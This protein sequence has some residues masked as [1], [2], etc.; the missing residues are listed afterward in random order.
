ME[1]LLKATQEMVQGAI[2]ILVLVCIDIPLKLALC[3]IFF[4]LGVICSI[5]YP[6]TRKLVCPRCVGLAYDY[7]TTDKLIAVKVL[8][9]WSD[10]GTL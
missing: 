9:A 8:K 5:L 2:T 1:E 3:I 4:I 10:E 7:T 6:I